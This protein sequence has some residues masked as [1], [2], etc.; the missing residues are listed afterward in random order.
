ML[1]SIEREGEDL[2][3]VR[4]SR[5]LGGHD[6]RKDIPVVGIDRVKR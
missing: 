3:C 5:L 6:K 2:V 4:F 1:L